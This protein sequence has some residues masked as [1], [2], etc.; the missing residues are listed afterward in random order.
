MESASLQWCMHAG[1]YFNRGKILGMLGREGEAQ[2]A[3]REAAL[4]TE[5]AAPGSYVKALA[6]LKTFD[7][8]LTARMEEAARFLKLAQGARSV[9]KGCTLPR[10]CQQCPAGRATEYSSTQ[11]A[12][13]IVNRRSGRKPGCINQ[14]LS[15]SFLLSSL[16]L[17]RTQL[18]LQAGTLC[19]CVQ[20][21]SAFCRER[22]R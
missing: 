17:Q 4:M 3:Y 5:G 1:A 8:A 22:Q 21:S 13:G 18:S 9:P 10:A 11:A 7:D 15:W 16:Q 19:R 20:T 2:E 14:A 6:S 12:V